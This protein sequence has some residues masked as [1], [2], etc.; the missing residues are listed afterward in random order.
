MKIMDVYSSTLAEN[1]WDAAYLA[2]DR[3]WTMTLTDADRALLWNDAARYRW[4]A[5]DA[6]RESLRGFLL[7][8]LRAMGFAHVRNLG[9]LTRPGVDV[10]AGFTFLLRQ[11]GRIVEQSGDGSLTQV[12]RGSQSDGATDLDYQC[13][14]S[15][16]LVLLYL[17]P[18]AD[19]GG[20]T[21]LASS[22][23]VV[24]LIRAER[25]DVLETLVRQDFGFDRRG[26]AGPQVIVRPIVK[27]LPGGAVDLYY[28][29]RT[30]RDTSSLYGPLTA[31]QL[32]ALAVL[33]E[34]LKRPSTGYGLS[35][36]SGDLLV[37]RNSRVLHGRSAQAAPL[38]S[39]PGRILQ[40]WMDTNEL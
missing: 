7:G 37:I 29:P 32:E 8:S 13:Y 6:L 19:S 2:S 5:A 4:D 15:D 10:P 40:I 23:T 31:D 21:R 34:V 39:L 18:A 27:I 9:G 17:Q 36:Q 16:L 30:V 14:T 24:D 25:P 33:D 26:K 38:S 11:I 20:Q 3:Q 1:A 12:L 28:Q 35:L 22:R